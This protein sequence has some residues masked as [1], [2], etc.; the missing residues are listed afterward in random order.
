MIDKYKV[1]GSCAKIK[2]K[3]I[4]SFLLVD[5]FVAFIVAFSFIYIDNMIVGAIL[6]VLLLFTIALTIWLI[7][8]PKDNLLYDNVN[9]QILIYA[10]H[11]FGNI[12]KPIIVN[13]KDVVKIQ[14][15]Y[16]SKKYKNTFSFVQIFD[17]KRSYKIIC[18]DEVKNVYDNILNIL[19]DTFF[20]NDYIG[21]ENMEKILSFDDDYFFKGVFEVLN[22]R[23]KY[24]DFSKEVFNIYI[25]LL[26][27]LTIHNG[28]INY[29]MLFYHEYLNNVID[30]FE[31]LGFPNVAEEVSKL[32]Y[33]YPH[34]NGNEFYEEVKENINNNESL[35]SLNNRLH[36]I[37]IYV[38]QSDNGYDYINNLKK[39]IIEN[40]INLI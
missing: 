19:P 13:T 21:D 8:I 31:L 20:I 9:K 37:T 36:E 29:F 38:F 6:G 26:F 22:K 24:N 16:N 1:I 5:V 14:A 40:N 33:L 27:I 32:Y 7:I 35:V 30:M 34:S 15:E 3:M 17:K 4:L 23:I 18:I 28:G 12:K 25:Y 10:F 11:T 2:K 39:Y